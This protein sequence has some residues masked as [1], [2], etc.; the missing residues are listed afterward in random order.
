MTPF[1]TL[2]QAAGL[3]SVQEAT[4]F[5][6]IRPATCRQYWYAER[7]IPPGIVG[8]LYTEYHN[9]IETDRKL[10]TMN[11]DQMVNFVNGKK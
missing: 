8:E 4:D 1:K 9:K 5:L 11:V 2:C 10:Y 7:D 3:M 6:G